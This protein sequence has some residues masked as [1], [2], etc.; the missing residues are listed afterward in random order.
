MRPSV[1]AEIQISHTQWTPDALCS[2]T[3]HVLGKWE[4]A[5][6]LT[7]SWTCIRGQWLLCQRSLLYHSTVLC[8]FP[9]LLTSREGQTQKE[10]TK[11]CFTINDSSSVR[12]QCKL[13]ILLY[14][15]QCILYLL[16]FLHVIMYCMTFGNCPPYEKL[17][18]TFDSLAAHCST[19]V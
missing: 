13:A 10:N 16:I 15:I 11:Y 5:V 9:S 12:F 14:K 8:S 18:D 6:S 17:T 3:E 2:Q 1:P 7:H 4:R 19:R